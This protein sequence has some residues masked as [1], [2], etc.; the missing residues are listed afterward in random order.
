MRTESE[1]RTGGS[2]LARRALDLLPESKKLRALVIAGLVAAL[3]G[4]AGGFLSAVGAAGFGFIDGGS[5]PVSVTGGSSTPTPKLDLLPPGTISRS[6]IGGDGVVVPEMINKIPRPPL[7]DEALLAWKA[8]VGAVDAYSTTVEFGATYL[9]DEPVIIT[10]VRPIV[11]RHGDP[12]RGVQIRPQGGGGLSSRIL[13]YDLDPT[14][15][16]VAQENDVSGKRW[17]FPLQISRG[18]SEFFVFIGRSS[19]G[20]VEWHIVV[21]FIYN[22]HQQSARIDNHGEPFRTTGT[23]AASQSLYFPDEEDRWPLYEPK[24]S[25]GAE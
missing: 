13:T 7:S 17:H 4:I 12:V 18:D 21:E 10:D 11:T 8:E 5:D 19:R 1:P 9:G 15:T 6:S 16:L 20:L 3:G 25:G 22:G 24:F 23:S 14:P 2:A